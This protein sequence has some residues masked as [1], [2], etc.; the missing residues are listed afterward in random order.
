MIV[1]GGYG[2]NLNALLAIGVFASLL[3]AQGLD[4]PFP[5]SSDNLGVMEMLDVELLA[6][7]IE[8]AADCPVAGDQIFN[9]ANGDT[10]VWPDLWPVIAG[11][12][13]IPVGRAAPLS[14]RDAVFG[15]AD[16]VAK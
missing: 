3:R 13:G 4:L 10:Y 16:A 15:R 6:H 1:G 5:G 8:W 9:V 2:G 11:E 12:I 7:A 14:V